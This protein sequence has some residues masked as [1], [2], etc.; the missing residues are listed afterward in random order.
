MHILV[1]EDEVLMAEALAARLKSEDR[2]CT[3]ATT[4]EAGLRL[5]RAG[6]FDLMVLDVML[7]RQSGLDVLRTLRRD[8]FT[9]P[10]LLLTSRNS[11]EDRVLGLDAG[12]DDYMVKPFAFP[13]LEARIRALL[14]RGAPHASSHLHLADLAIN[15]AG[16]TA[17]RGGHTLDLTEREFDLLE[18]L[19][20]NRGTVVS[21]R[22]LAREIW[23]ETTRH[24]S[25]DNVIDVQIG[26]LR[27]KLGEP[28]NRRLL[29][30]V[31][32]V[33]YV[34]REPVE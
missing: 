10:T 8:G 33:G 13:E 27:R 6:S 22:T 11:I 7:P 29:H 34:L 5:L 30:T 15:V 24:T 19:L 16:R 28:H 32:G 18:Y 20:R 14:R 9:L 26:R 21:R 12:A 1:I 4:G 3:I 23:K 17:T 31:R 2:E 25:L